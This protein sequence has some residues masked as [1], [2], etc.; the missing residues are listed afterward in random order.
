MRESRTEPARFPTLP[1]KSLTRVCF[2]LFSSC[3]LALNIH[4]DAPVPRQAMPPECD[5]MR[6]DRLTIHGS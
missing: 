4:R 5:I 2:G 6:C 3:R 1:G